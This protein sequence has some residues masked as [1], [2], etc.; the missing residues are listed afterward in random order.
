MESVCFSINF[1]EIM[2]MNPIFMQQ[3]SNPL[4]FLG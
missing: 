2:Y 1:K 3:T 4:G